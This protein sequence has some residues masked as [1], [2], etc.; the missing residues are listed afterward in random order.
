MNKV[1][2]IAFRAG[3][4]ELLLLVV[5]AFLFGGVEHMQGLK[6]PIPFLVVLQVGALLGA[7]A[8]LLGTL[9]LWVVGW[10]FILQGWRTRSWLLSFV[11]I[12]TIVF[13]NVLAA[14]CFHILRQRQRKHP[15]A[16]PQ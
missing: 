10:F 3:I 16:L 12:I 13:F 1:F 15:T 4:S 6:K 2:N 8:W 7:I 11:F 9:V 5:M 14:Y